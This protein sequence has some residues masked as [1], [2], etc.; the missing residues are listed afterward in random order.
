MFVGGEKV[1]RVGREHALHELR[2]G[3]WS[4]RE[5]LDERGDVCAL[6]GRLE[7]RGL[8]RLLHVNRNGGPL[9]K[10]R[11]WTEKMEPADWSD[12]FFTTLCH[13]ASVA[14][15]D[16]SGIVAIDEPENSLHPELIVKLIEAMRDWSKQRGVTIVLA[17]HSPVVL[18]QF[19]DEPEKVFVMQAGH[20]QQPVPL[21]QL[22]QRDWLRHF[23]LGDLY[24]HLEIG[25]SRR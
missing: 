20:E 16:Q 21:D 17:T 4:P 12:G 14:S 9:V 15:V 11:T 6:A 24:S 22:K 1:R 8:E 18:D 25:A 5:H 10:G 3:G 19:R 2:L 23:S 13:L 7:H